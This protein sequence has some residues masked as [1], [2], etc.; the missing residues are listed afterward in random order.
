MVKQS[1]EK[2]AER[3]DSKF[4]GVRKRKWGKWV[5]EIR[6]PHSRERIWLG[7]YDSAEKAALAFDAAMFCLRGRS[8][9][10]NFPD[11]P[12]DIAGGRSM[13]PS[14]IQAAAACF[15]NSEPRM[16]QT[17]NKSETSDLP[18]ESP[19]PSLS[20]VTVQTE[21]EVTQN[22]SFPDLFSAIGSGNYGTEYGIFAG[23][24]DLSSGFYIPEMASVDY[25][26]ESMDGLIIEDSFLWNF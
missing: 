6:L 15:A 9:N 2:P 12:P 13:S 20:E 24:D 4:R 14:Q 16:V 11:N 25:G 17:G 10:F 19:S 3:S 22:E 23:F 8:G 5:S 7:S 26:D 1:T 18:M 21:S